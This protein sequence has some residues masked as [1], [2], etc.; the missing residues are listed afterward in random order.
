MT[1]FDARRALLVRGDIFAP[2]RVKTTRPLSD[3]LAG[4]SLPQ[5][6]LRAD[7][8]V[9]VAEW[10]AAPVVLLKRHMAFHHVAQGEI[11]GEPWLVSL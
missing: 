8:P 1:A 9:V 10:F 5:R 7:E 2:F 3:A 6:V 4:G 11:A